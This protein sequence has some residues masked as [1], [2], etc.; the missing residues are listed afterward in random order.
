MLYFRPVDRPKDFSFIHRVIMHPAVV[1]LAGVL[2]YFACLRETPLFWT[3]A[4]GYPIW[5][6]D[7][8]LETFY[9]LLSMYGGLV[10]FLSWQWIRKPSHSARL[11]WME[12]V[13]VLVLWS[14]GG[15]VTVIVVANNVSNLIEG[16]PFHS[17]V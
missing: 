4:G 17:H 16:R 1:L 7:M 6:R 5:L 11:F 9:P 8:V 10:A 14:A 13:S 3:N 12:A 2:V 15:L